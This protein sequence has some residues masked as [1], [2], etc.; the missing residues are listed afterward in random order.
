[1]RNASV[2][3]AVVG[4]LPL[5]GLTMIYDLGLSGLWAALTAFIVVRCALVAARTARGRW[6]VTGAVR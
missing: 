1:M 3:G 6:A 5:A 2:V 4:Y